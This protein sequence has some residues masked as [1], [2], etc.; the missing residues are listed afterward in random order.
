MKTWRDRTSTR[1]QRL[2]LTCACCVIVLLGANQIPAAAQNRGALGA[3][4]RDLLR[5]GPTI[6]WGTPAPSAAVM[7]DRLH[8]EVARVQFQLNDP[9][10]GGERALHDGDATQLAAGTP[11][12]AIAG[13]RADFRV[14]ALGSDGGPILY[15]AAISETA[16]TGADLLDTIRRRRGGQRAHLVGVLARDTK[17]LARGR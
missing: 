6:Y 4:G 7:P 11:I 10:P 12:Y 16:H 1:S 14:A 8:Q 9:G 17:S 2:V 13:Y 3:S 15:Q 5:I